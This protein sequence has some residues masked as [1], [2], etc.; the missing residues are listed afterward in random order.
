MG[1]DKTFFGLYS[2]Q[3]RDSKG[4]TSFILFLTNIMVVGQSIKK[5]YCE[6]RLTS[7]NP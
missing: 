1:D 6:Q 7:L 3:Q 5:N 2:H 4:K